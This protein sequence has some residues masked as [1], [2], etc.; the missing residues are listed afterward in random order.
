MKRPSKTP[1]KPKF[2]SL[3][4]LRQLNP[5][6]FGKTLDVSSWQDGAEVL[7]DKKVRFKLWAP[8]AAE[9]EL[10]KIRP[11]SHAEQQGNAPKVTERIVDVVPMHSDDGNMFFLPE[12]HGKNTFKPGDL[13]MFRLKYDDGALSKPLPDYN[14]R[15]QPEDVHG[16]SMIYDHS[17]FKWD[18]HHW[19]TPSDVRKLTPY[20]LHIGTFTQAGTFEAA[21]D[22]F[23]NETLKKG[24]NYNA[25]EIMPVMEFS[26]KWNWGYDMVN[27][28]AVENA[29]GPPEKLK[30]F[31]NECHKRNIAVVLDTVYNHVGPEGAYFTQFDRGFVRHG[32]TDWGDAFNLDNPHARRYVLENVKFWL[33]EFHIDGFRFD[34]TKYI[35][36]DFVRE[37]TKTAYNAKKAAF[38]DNPHVIPM[39]EDARNWNSVTMPHDWHWDEHDGRRHMGH[40]MKAQWNFDF[41]HAAQGIV[42]GHSHM[43]GPTDPGSFANVLERGFRWPDGNAMRELE[44]SVN[45]TQSH[46]EIGNNDGMRVYAKVGP[47]RARLSAVL[48]YLIPG[49]PMAFAGEEYGEKN[50]FYYFVNHSDPVLVKNIEKGQRDKR[51]PQPSWTSPKNFTDSK[52]SWNQDLGMLRLNRD[53]VK[54]RQTMPALWQGG[55]DQMWVDRRLANKGLLAIHR[56]GKEDDKSHVVMVINCSWH[57]FQYDPQ[58]KHHGMTVPF[59]QG[60]KWREILNTDDAQYGGSNATNKDRDMEGDQPISLKAG[61]VAIFSKV[62]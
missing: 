19:K 25:V 18:D 20:R 33:K 43:G 35:S 7:A 10:L 37:I 59:P 28:Y 14:T 46:D 9:V 58:K 26:G 52:L 11:L 13:Y 23:F 34:M 56:W 53:I 22:Q 31:I 36:E 44:Q 57:D 39:A 21:M 3:Q 24:P 17:T 61:S 32:A 8:A 16:P 49:I 27:F 30:K 2:G 15:Y 40:G 48:K 55:R 60:G 4:A 41:H 42:T 54:L 6:R 1:P 38:P 45:F 5:L 47:Q 29:Y 51:S 50:P 12:T 62:K